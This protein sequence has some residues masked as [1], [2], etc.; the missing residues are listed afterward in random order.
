NTYTGTTTVTGGKLVVGG[1]GYSNASL[2]GAVT[3]AAGGTLG[4]SGTV[5]T[6]TLAAGSTLA[7]GN[8]IGTLT[9]DGDLTLAAGS[10]YQTEIAGNGSSDRI[11][12][13][14]VATVAGGHVEVTALD[15]KT[16]YQDGQS[17]TILTAAG[18]IS[19][20]FADA[21]TQSAFLDLSLEN[22][23]N[24]VDLIIKLKNTDPSPE[25]E[26]PGEP[27]PLFVTVANTGNQLAA[28]GALDTLAQS[29][30]SLGLYNK[31]LMLNANQARTAFDGL[32]GEIHAS[33]KTAL[34][35]DSRFVR[36]AANDRVRAAFGDI[37]ASAAPVIA[38]DHGGPVAV[39]ATT[40][41]LAV[42]GQGFGSW[43]HNDSNGNA[44]R[45]DHDTGGFLA[46]ADTQ[47]FDSWRLGLLAG[48]SRS[49]FDVHDRGSSGTSDNVHLGLYGGTSWNL[50]GGTL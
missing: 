44:A 32:S 26:G 48:Y 39:A 40:E 1:M 46:G 38:Y 43:G 50:S 14:G 27:K 41:A 11:A 13:T 9:V 45:L 24:A 20:Q 31:L 15:A 7:P 3:V 4:G 17:Y 33:A 8:S 42:W 35:E 16:S 6:T 34:I 49:N 19:G 28:A 2:A 23:P 21:V 37:G 12:V 29:G 5:G 47:V 22:Q 30:P 25:P 18:G 10:I 36:D